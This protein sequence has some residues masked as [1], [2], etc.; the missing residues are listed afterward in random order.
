MSTTQSPAV[1]MPFTP[2]SRCA[3]FA[4]WILLVLSAT[5]LAGWEFRSTV[6][7]SIIPGL[8]SMKPNTAVAF[9]L[10]GLAFIRRERRDFLL[11]PFLVLAIG[12]ITLFEFISGANLGIDQ[13]L[14]HDPESVPAPGRMSLITSLA[15]VLFGASLSLMT[16]KTARLRRLSRILALAGGALGGIAIL[17]YT[18]DTQALYRV[19]PYSSVAL[20]TA[21][22]LVIAA[23]GVQCAHSNEG[24][25]RLVRAQNTGGA[26]LRQLL[27]AALFVPYL[28]GLAAWLAHL[29]LGW[30]MGF[31]LALVIA[32]TMLCLVVIMVLNARRL[33]R[34]DV[35][36]SE[37]FGAL[38]QRTALL[39]A[40]EDLLSMFVKHVPAAVAMLDR[41]MAYL[42]VSDRWCADY[43][44]DS[45]SVL[46]RSHYDIFP[47]LPERW[48]ELHRRCL[49]GETLHVEEDRWDRRDGS[50]LW[51]HWEVRPWGSLDGVP[52]GILIFSEDITVRKQAETALRQS[53][54][55]L[56]IL[57]GS[58]LTAQEDERRRLSRELH[59]DI[60][61]RLAF[62]SIELGKLAGQLP[63]SL[64]ELQNTLRSLQQQTL[65]TSTEVRRLSHGL[66]PSVIEDFGLSTALEDFCE[67][68][69]KAMEVNVT[70]HAQA[71]DSQLDAVSSTCLYRITQE[72][73]RNAV[74]HGHATVISV[75]LSGGPA[76]LELR[77]KDNGVGFAAEGARSKS[78][79]GLV[80]MRERLR[81]VNGT[82][83]LNSQPGQGAEIVAAVPLQG[84]GNEEASYSAGR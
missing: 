3:S 29:H 63:L 30:E 46:G 79:L 32:G 81:L 16:A 11:Y 21:V 69:E 35:G 59:D 49:A 68:F 39:Q 51:L 24:L 44:L 7:T 71:D 22:A 18:Y 64:E 5:V 82:L 42:Q 45:A 54:Q 66:H 58:L 37:M 61:Q 41:N 40:R 72:C 47:D 76:H 77:I 73:L 65:E 19:R 15:F 6:L 83:N 9:L 43:A 38:K 60:T 48:R 50:T 84:A 74:V 28:L 75:T 53:E 52:E 33:E 34:K 67:E 57:A 78:G 14:F 56:H 12:A 23:I 62:L 1:P 2:A 25:L 13:L 4:G 31:S 70:F 17:G 26:M 20:H 55:Q 27:P 80:S 36:L 10:I 8:A